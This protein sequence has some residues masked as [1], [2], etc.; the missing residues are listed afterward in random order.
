MNDK[1][2]NREST[3]PEDT[4]KDEI[5]E[6]SAYNGRENPIPEEGIKD[7]GD[8]SYYAGSAPE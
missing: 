8:S 6:S 5:L 2:I 3:K 7:N 1:N 4:Y